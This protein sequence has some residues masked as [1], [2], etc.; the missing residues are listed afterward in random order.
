MVKQDFSLNGT[1]APVIYTLSLHDALPIS[2]MWQIPSR[3]TSGCIASILLPG[4]WRCQRR[5]GHDAGYV[6][7]G[8]VVEDREVGLCGEDGSYDHGQL[9]PRRAARGLPLAGTVLAVRQRNL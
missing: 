6:P 4:L 1:D 7:P 2:P 5:S 8:S 9:R 3:T